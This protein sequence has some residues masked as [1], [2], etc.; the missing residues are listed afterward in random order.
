[1]KAIITKKGKDTVNKFIEKY[2]ALYERAKLDEKVNLDDIFAVPQE[3]EICR[4]IVFMHNRVMDNGFYEAI[5]TAVDN[6]GDS[7]Y[8]LT[9]HLNSDEFTF[10]E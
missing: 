1:M 10:V 4:D 6:R 8:N 5:W 3:E 7:E 2:K 9:L